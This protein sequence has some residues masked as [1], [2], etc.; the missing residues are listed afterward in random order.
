MPSGY[1]DEGESPKQASIR[2][3]EE[4]TGYEAK[5]IIALGTY[6]LDYT[7]FE[8]KGNLFIA[9]GLMKKKEQSLG[10]MEKIDVKIMKIKEIKQL[11]SEGKISN[12]A[13][14]VAFY[15]AS[16]FS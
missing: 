16:R 1:I 10:I 15:K 13:S 12:A 14:I 4:E 8:Q 11:L 7:M 2:E 3:L 6:T 9:Y 5:E